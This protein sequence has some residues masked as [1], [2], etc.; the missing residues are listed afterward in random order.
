MVSNFCADNASVNFGKFNSVFT[1]LQSVK[2]TLIKANCLCHVINNMVKNASKAFKVD[3]ESVVIKIYNEFSSSAKRTE[4]LKS[5]FEFVDLEYQ[6]LL[7]HVPTRW[8]SL[9]PAIDRL[10]KN[11]SAVK[12]YFQSEGEANNA[13]IILETFQDD[14]E[15]SLPLCTL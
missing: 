6:D 15:N 7:R 9:H 2:P 3:V 12:S 8:L 1:K 13:A 4:N 5:F 11:W 14:D 10:L